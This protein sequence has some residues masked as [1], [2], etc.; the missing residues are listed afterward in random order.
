MTK[1]NDASPLRNADQLTH[2][3]ISEQLTNLTLKIPIIYEELDFEIYSNTLL[4]SYFW[5]VDPLTESKIL[6][7]AMADLLL[8]ITLSKDAK[9]VLGVVFLPVTNTCYYINKA[10]KQ[11][12]PSSKLENNHPKNYN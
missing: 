8:I 11:L 3:F 7:N 5:L 6:L 9:V 10:V 12:A 4:N 2:D 1:K